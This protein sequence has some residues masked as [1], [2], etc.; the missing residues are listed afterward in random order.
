MT[1]ATVL[2]GVLVA[3]A[4]SVPVGAAVRLAW[5]WLDPMPDPPA[6]PPAPA[7]AVPATAPRWWTPDAPAWAVAPIGQSVRCLGEQAEA[8]HLEPAA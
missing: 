7:P 2:L 6:S 5:L 3:L 8:R 4:G 1:A